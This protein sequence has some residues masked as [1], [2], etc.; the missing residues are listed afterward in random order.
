MIQV[1]GFNSLDHWRLHWIYLVRFRGHVQCLN[2]AKEKLFLQ[3][4]WRPGKFA[5]ACH[6]IQMQITNSI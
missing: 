5:Y 2:Y 4:D 6:I 3:H 1:F